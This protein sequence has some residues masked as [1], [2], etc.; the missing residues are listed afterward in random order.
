MTSLSF[1]GSCNYR[2]YFYLQAL[3]K[4]KI[5]LKSTIIYNYQK[6]DLSKHRNENISYKDLEIQFSESLDELLDYFNA[7]VVKSESINNL[8]EEI[9]KDKSDIYI[10]S[11]KGGEIVKSNILRNSKFLHIHPGKLPMYRGSTTI[12]YSLLKEKRCTATAFYLDT[13]IDTGNIIK[14]MDFKILDIDFDYLY[15]PLI[16]TYLLIDIVKN[17]IF[18]SS[19]QANIDKKEYYIIHPVLKK[20]ALLKKKDVVNES[21]LGI[22]NN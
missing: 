18:K 16:R 10:F 11:G 14:E 20:I 19:E 21:N 9:K 6:L 7:K 8:E 4:N 1:I 12:Y 13:K 15:D 3:K 2:T 5:K 17:S 22:E